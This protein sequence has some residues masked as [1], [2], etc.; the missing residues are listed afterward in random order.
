MS[1]R[2]PQHEE[3]PREVGIWP[4][5]ENDNAYLFHTSGTS[6][7][8]PK[9][10]AQNHHG[11]V[12]VLPFLAQGKDEATL[13][14]TPLYHGG[15]ADC[16]RAWTSQAMIWLFPARDTPITATNILKSV[17]CSYKATQLHK[18]P[19]VRYFSSVP[20][21]LQMLAEDREGLQMLKTMSLVGVGGAALPE[22]VGNNLVAQAVNLVSRYG[23]AEC[24]FLLSSHRSYATDKA[25]AYLR[26]N[27]F[28][29]LSFERRDDGLSELIV[30]PSWPHMAKTNRDNGAYATA[31]LFEA[32]ADIADA[33]RY[34]SRADAQLTLMTGKKFDPEPL[35]AAMATHPFISE[36]L[37]FGNGRLCAGVLVF[38][39]AAAGAEVSEEVWQHVEKLNVHSQSHARISKSMVTI[40]PFQ[41][42]TLAKSSKGTIMR[43]V[44]EKKYASYIDNAYGDSDEHTG[45]A[46]PNN[47][48]PARVRQIVTAITGIQ[49]SSGEDEGHG[50]AAATGIQAS[51][52]DDEDLFS[53]GVDSIAAMRI[54]Q[55]LQKELNIEHLPLNIVYDC[56]TLGKLSAFLV[57]IRE[58]SHAE[59]SDEIQEMRDLVSKYGNF[60]ANLAVSG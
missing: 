12:G 28:G 51:L 50:I 52:G 56:G 18:T 20:F 41:A 32:H 10:V 3:R 5:S 45:R 49:A 9:P 39:S 22:E 17:R 60:G 38:P 40:M 59:T 8:L 37:I 42:S 58:G 33:W 46:I 21:V 35:E 27:K 57:A 53:L 1:P 19:A 4:S 16:F 55:S 2:Q 14:I 24:G 13:T 15:I 30:N 34:H 23:S 43:R 29:Y 11:A 6:S 31:D 25:W 54:R 44:A 47:A 36:A 48:I 26:D 7:G